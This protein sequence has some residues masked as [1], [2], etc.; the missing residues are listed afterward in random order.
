VDRVVVCGVHAEMLHEA[1]KNARWEAYKRKFMKMYYWELDC[2][3][4]GITVYI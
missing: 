4:V 2:K 1:R 3:C